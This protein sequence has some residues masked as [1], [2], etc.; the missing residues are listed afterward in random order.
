MNEVVFTNFLRYK[1]DGKACGLLIGLQCMLEVMWLHIYS[2]LV[3][4]DW[5]CE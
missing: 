1:S 2:E 4:L 3:D 5:D